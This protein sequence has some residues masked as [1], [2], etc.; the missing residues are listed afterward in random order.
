MEN[1]ASINSAPLN[2]DNFVTFIHI[3]ALFL[4]I[5]YI[6]LFNTKLKRT[7]ANKENNNII[8]IDNRGIVIDEE[9]DE[10]EEKY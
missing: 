10:N 6:F 2:H 7:E 5:I 3:F 9:E 4:V 8:G 1:S